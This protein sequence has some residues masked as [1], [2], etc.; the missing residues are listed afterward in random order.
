MRNSDEGCE[1]GLSRGAV[2]INTALEAVMPDPMASIHLDKNS[3]RDMFRNAR[4]ALQQACGA[5]T[6]ISDGRLLEADE[7]VDCPTVAV[8]PASA[9]TPP[10]L[11]SKFICYLQDGEH[12]YPLH[13]GMNSVGRLNDNDVVIRDECVSRR[14]CAVLVHSDFRCELH[15]VASKNGT[16][17]NDQ[18]IDGPTR[19]FSGDRISLSSKTLTFMISA[20][21]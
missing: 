1:V 20:N 13:V 18:K 16:L 9:D 10:A 4:Q 12:A 2:L 5:N 15:D 11:G 7:E 21:G 19:I 8:P 3:R 17:L 14:H 6:L